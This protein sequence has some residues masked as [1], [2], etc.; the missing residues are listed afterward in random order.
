MEKPRYGRRR[1]A[2]IEW[3][4]SDNGVSGGKMMTGS[5]VKMAANNQERDKSSGR[6]GSRRAGGRRHQ[7][8][9]EGNQQWA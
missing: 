8:V 7:A 2:G 3:T 4:N 5:N 9:I 1:Q 6:A